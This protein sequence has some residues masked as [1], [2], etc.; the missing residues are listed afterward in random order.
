MQYHKTVDPETCILNGNKVLE[1]FL[2]KCNQYFVSTSITEILKAFNE[3]MTT[4]MFSEG[5]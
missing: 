5:A 3:V 2:E 4:T 1:H